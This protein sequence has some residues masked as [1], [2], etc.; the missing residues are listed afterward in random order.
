[1]GKLP[2]SGTARTVLF[3]A[4]VSGF[5]WLFFLFAS[6]FI[7]TFIFQ[8]TT[9][10]MKRV[11]DVWRGSL[12]FQLCTHQKQTK[13][14]KSDIENRKKGRRRGGT[15]LITKASRSAVGNSLGC[16]GCRLQPLFF[17]PSSSFPPRRETHAE[18][19]ESLDASPPKKTNHTDDV[20]PVLLPA[21][22]FAIGSCP[23]QRVRS[24]F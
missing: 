2:A 8:L 23:L 3:S 22:A 15:S 14:I 13:P 21:I 4:A 19:T 17:S 5:P 11:N 20:S 1:M 12:V 7:S 18:I 16:S 6:A 24:Y 9:A 10:I